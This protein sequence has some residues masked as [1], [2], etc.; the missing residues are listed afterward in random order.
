MPKFIPTALH[1]EAE[2]SHQL[3]YCSH[4]GDR[5]GEKCRQQ[6]TEEEGC[7]EGEEILVHGLEII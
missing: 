2:F 6:E 3:C 4:Q 1:R 7:E 5:L